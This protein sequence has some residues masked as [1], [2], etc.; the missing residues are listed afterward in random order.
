VAEHHGIAAVGL[1]Q[2]RKLPSFLEKRRNNAEYLGEKV[3]MLGKV[4]RLSR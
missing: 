1:A 3:G 2:L 4:A